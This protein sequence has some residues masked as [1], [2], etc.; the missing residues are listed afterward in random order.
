MNPPDRVMIFAIEP[1]R[2]VAIASTLEAAGFLVTRHDQPHTAVEVLR[3]LRPALIVVAEANESHSSSFPHLCE[4]AR[5]LKIPALAVQVVGSAPSLVAAYEDWVSEA[6]IFSE[7]PLRARRLV[8]RPVG[9]LSPAID[10]QFLALVVHDL[11]TPLNVINLTIRAISQ[12]VPTPSADFNEDLSFLQEN[13]KQIEKMLAQLGDY[14][15]LVESEQR[16]GGIEFE[17]T[18]LLDRFSGRKTVQTR[19]GIQ[20]GPT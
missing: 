16:P 20:G 1:S 19:L 12:S 8:D 6:S 4:S 9:L 2:A 14:C 15:R 7:L 3:R 11:R 17:T 18:P 13:S 10:P 5:G